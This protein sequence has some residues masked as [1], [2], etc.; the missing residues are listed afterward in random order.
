MFV[1]NSKILLYMCLLLISCRAPLPL[2]GGCLFLRSLLS[3]VGRWEGWARACVSLDPCNSC[4]W[5]FTLNSVSSG[6]FWTV[7]KHLLKFTLLFV[8]QMSCAFE[9]VLVAPFKNMSLSSADLS[10]LGFAVFRQ[11]SPVIWAPFAGALAQFLF[12]DLWLQAM[13]GFSPAKDSSRDT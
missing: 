8:P 4:L 7:Q 1:G 6:N 12:F 3:Q 9:N 11:L 2:R 5:T 13:M 10:T